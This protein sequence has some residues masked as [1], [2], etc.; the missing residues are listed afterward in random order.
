MFK[1][2]KVSYLNTLPLFYSLE[3]FEVV[4]GVPSELVEKLR[5]GEIHAGIVSSVEYFFNPQD[6]F[7]LSGISISSRGSVCSVKLFS[8]EPM[9]KIREVNITKASLTS[10]EL[11]F[12]LFEKKFGFVPKES[13]EAQAKLLIGDEA[14]EQKGYKF[15]YDLGEEWFKLHGLPFVFALFLVK[16]DADISKAK[17]LKKEI[18]KSVKN[19]FEEGIKNIKNKEYFKNCLDYSLGGEHIKSLINFYAYLSRKFK[20]Q[21]PKLKFVL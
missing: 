1:V 10:R 21:V 8:N 13:E 9:E 11:L 6:Y 15:V 7:I 5:R 14:M 17:F 4:E 12:Y 18:K 20:K 19:F 16:R 3:G 2:G